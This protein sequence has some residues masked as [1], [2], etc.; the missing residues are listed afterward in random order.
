MVGKVAEG[1]VE[2]P[3]HPPIHGSL[4]SVDIGNTEGEKGELALGA[5]VLPSHLEGST[6]TH[7]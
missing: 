1:I 6:V 2:T 4:D 5:E 3:P 7:V